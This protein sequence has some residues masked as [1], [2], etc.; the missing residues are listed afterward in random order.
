MRISPC[1][2][3]DF[4]ARLLISVFFLHICIGWMGGP[5]QN[6][7]EH[8]GKKR[9]PFWR[10]FFLG[11]GDLHMFNNNNSVVPMIISIFVFLFLL[12]LVMISK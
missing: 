2:K 11:K 7:R 8:N 9:K 1:L 6:W 4:F 5:K 12:G 10:F 3:S